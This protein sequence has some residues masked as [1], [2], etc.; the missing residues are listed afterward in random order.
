LAQADPTL[1]WRNDGDTSQIILEGMGE[2]HVMVALGRADKLGVGILTEMPKVPYKETVTKKA[3]ASYRHKKQSGGAGQFG[4]ITL[5]VEPNPGG[6]FV[7]E[8][9]VSGGAVTEQFLDSAHKGILQVIPTG[10]IAGYPVVDVHVR[11]YDGKMHPVDSK[12]IAFQ[13]AG[14]ESFKEAFKEAGPVLLEPIMDVKITVPETMMGD[15][16]SDLNTRRGRVQGMDT[17][18]GGKSI[19]SAQ[20]PLAE[21]LRYGNDLRSMSG[22]RGIYSMSFAHYERVPSNIAEPIVKSYSPHSAAE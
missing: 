21:M 3:D 12:D 18:G 6:G 14:R 2:I 15:I 20:V 8:A 9:K 16:M 5:F 13:I 1:R 22:G 19:V 17:T 4:E 11:V 7:Y 10:V